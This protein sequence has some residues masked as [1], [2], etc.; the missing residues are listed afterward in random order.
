MNFRHLLGC[1]TIG[2]LSKRRREARRRHLYYG[3]TKSQRFVVEFLP[4]RARFW[5]AT[6]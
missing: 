2:T 5:F 1:D 6:G 3:V 4:F